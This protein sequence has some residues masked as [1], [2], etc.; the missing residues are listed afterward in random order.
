[1]SESPSWL[2]RFIG[3]ILVIIGVMTM[4]LSGSCASLA[5]MMAPV[6]EHGGGSDMLDIAVWCAVAGAVGLGL[7][8][9]GRRLRGSSTPPKLEVPLPP[10]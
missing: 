4:V 6:M 1:M 3:L 9:L 8:L 5:L 2:G 10:E 7:F